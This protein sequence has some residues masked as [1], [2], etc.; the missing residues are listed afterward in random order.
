MRTD[1]YDSFRY[2][3]SFRLN[4]YVSYNY[5]KFNNYII[6]FTGTHIHICDR[7]M[8][9]DGNILWSIQK[10]AR[11]IGTL[12]GARVYTGYRAGVSVTRGSLVRQ[13]RST[14]TRISQRRTFLRPSGCERPGNSAASS[15]SR[16]ST[17]RSKRQQFFQSGGIAESP[18]RLLFS[19]EPRAR[20]CSTQHT[21]GL[22]REGQKERRA[23]AAALRLSSSQS[24]APAR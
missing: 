22:L 2:L 14:K 18:P 12:T 1:S 17:I 3:L 9:N 21:R 23:S 8:N 7:V 4:I 16:H 11:Y 10:F 5:L 13:C 19:A 15:P 24:Q 6:F 20:P